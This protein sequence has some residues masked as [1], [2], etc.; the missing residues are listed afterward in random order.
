[1]FGNTKKIKDL[2]GKIEALQDLCTLIVNNSVEL[3][4]EYSLFAETIKKLLAHQQLIDTLLE[5]SKYKLMA[6]NDDDDFLN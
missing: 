1:M 6:S 5:D 2:E 4:R 3:T